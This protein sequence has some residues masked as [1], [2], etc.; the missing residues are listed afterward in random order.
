MEGTVEW[1]GKKRSFKQKIGSVNTARPSGCYAK[2]GT[3]SGNI[4]LPTPPA[5]E[6]ADLKV[7][8]AVKGYPAKATDHYNVGYS[9]DKSIGNYE[10]HPNLAS[11]QRSD[12][13]F[14]DIIHYAWKELPD[15]TEVSAYISCRDVPGGGQ[16]IKFNAPLNVGKETE[17]KFTYTFGKGWTVLVGTQKSI[18]APTTPPE[19][20]EKQKI[21]T[22]DPALKAVFESMFAGKTYEESVKLLGEWRDTWTKKHPS[23]KGE[24]DRSYKLAVE[25]LPERE[26]PSLETMEQQL[27]SNIKDKTKLEAIGMI[28]SWAQSKKYLFPHLS[29]DIDKIM[30]EILGELYEFREP[31]KMKIQ[32]VTEE[33]VDEWTAPMFRDFPEDLKDRFAWKDKASAWLKATFTHPINT[34]AG[35]IDIFSE[36]QGISKEEAGLVFDHITKTMSWISG[37]AVVG[38][39]TAIAMMGMV[40]VGGITALSTFVASKGGKAALPAVESTGWLAA[41]LASIKKNPILAAL[42]LT[43]LDTT[44]WGPEM[45]SKLT[46][47]EAK[48][49]ETLTYDVTNNIKK[50]HNLVTIKPTAA[51]KAEALSLLRITKPLLEEMLDLIEKRDIIR[52]VKDKFPDYEVKLNTY[53]AEFNNLISR[54]G[55][56]S[57]DF[58]DVGVLAAPTEPTLVELTEKF[59]KEFTLS[60]VQVEDGDTLIFPDHP[61]VENA[62]RILGIDTKEMDTEAG[63]EQAEYLKSLIEGATVTIK[64]HEHKDPAMMF[65]LYGRLLGGVFYGGND[66]ALKMLE[67]FGEEILAAKKYR[68]KY[69]WIDW[70]E[71]ERVAKKKVKEEEIG[72]IKINTKPTYAKIFLD[73]KD[74][75]LL[76]AEILKEIPLGKHKIKLTKFGYADFETEIDVKEPKRYEIY[77]DF[78]GVEEDVTGE[79]EKEAMT[80]SIDSTP[81]RAKVTIDDVY[82]H[83]LTPTDQK[84]QRDVKHLWTVGSHKIRLEKGGYSAELEIDLIDG[85]NEPIT[86]ELKGMV[87][88]EVE[89]EAPPEV[90]PPAELPTLQDF[91]TELWTYYVGRA[92]LSKTE[93]QVLAD[94][95]DLK[96]KEPYKELPAGQLPTIQ[97][98]WNEIL[99]YYVGRL[100]MSKTELEDLGDK[101]GLTY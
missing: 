56:T 77:H 61:E 7:I 100:Y 3:L 29:D 47:K 82:T 50:A 94:K 74:T 35:F 5:F 58:I 4:Y 54:A 65:G 23:W 27:R 34:R 21:V 15:T 32:P 42:V 40:A 84:E 63:K 31:P 36:E 87:T 24:I 14:E 10:N 16:G 79:S 71:Y 76:S 17:I 39:V 62:I 59:D 89:P 22:W 48:R 11:F 67:K 43:Q 2:Y 19:A 51:T 91:Y 83:H 80:F 28:T 68:K 41:I 88:E 75:N 93:I 57:A 26:A 72:Q 101:Y 81:T 12:G 25:L 92:Y 97:E 66:I 55:G 1:C 37:V 53:I 86:L 6:Y 70:D 95:Y 38:T 33:V 64:T 78:T 69:R 8:V 20:L 9:F 18:G 30:E 60:K 13:T 45:L 44:L 49:F 90:A 96:M 52:K 99:T 85:K 46:G 73:D 98:F